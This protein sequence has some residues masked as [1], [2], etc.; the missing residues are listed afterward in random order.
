MNF[1]SDFIYAKKRSQSQLPA[2][3]TSSN[4]GD[5]AG[6]LFR[7]QTA[8]NDDSDLD[9][10]VV[11]AKFDQLV[12]RSNTYTGDYYPCGNCGAILSCVSKVSQPNS[13]DNKSTWICDFCAFENKFKIEKEEIPTKEEVTYI[14]EG[15]VEKH[16]AEATENS[17]AK[18]LSMPFNS[19]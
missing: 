15:P 1:A 7:C 6:G 8:S 3:S 13:I 18:Y 17:D 5:N 10:N 16:E 11:S 12:E 19:S 2:P 9:T 14:L 4:G